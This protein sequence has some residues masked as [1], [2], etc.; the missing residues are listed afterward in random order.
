MT[1]SAYCTNVYID[2]SN[3]TTSNTFFR[4]Y[5]V[6]S[7]DSCFYTITARD[8]A[9]NVNTTTPQKVTLDVIAPNISYNANSDVAGYKTVNYIFM[10]IT[11]NDTN[12]KN[13]TLYLYK[14]GVL[15]QTINSTNLTS[16]V[17]F[18]SL[19]DASYSVNATSCDLANNCANLATRNI[20]TDASIPVVSF[21][22]PTMA[23]DTHIAQDYIPINSSVADSNFANQTIYI[24]NINGT[25]VDSSFSTNAV[26]FYNKTS[27]ANGE[28]LFNVTAY[29]L[30]N[31]RGYSE[32]R[33]ITLDTT[34]PIINL[35]AP[36]P[37]NNTVA[38]NI[39]LPINIT[40]STPN[41]KNI[42]VRLSNS[43]TLLYTNTSSV[44]NVTPAYFINYL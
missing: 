29:D 38:G 37:L 22:A 16:S 10:N 20:T 44:V 14:A 41:I 19:L 42:T 28:Y 30:A 23:N 26:Y 8:L 36:T 6:P 5:S 9:G 12:Y 21:V 13:T 2:T 27:L 34:I 4:N 31:N 32:T 33:N 35:V 11:V 40:V 3:F 17:N 7:S 39:S 1:V 25:L 18:T 15:N 43:T 24:Y